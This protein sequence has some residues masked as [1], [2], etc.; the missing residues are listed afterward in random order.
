MEAGY[1]IIRLYHITDSSRYKFQA[2]FKGIFLKSWTEHGRV[3]TISKD[4]C[5]ICIIDNNFFSELN[6]TLHFFIY[7]LVW[8]DW[9][10]RNIE[11]AVLPFTT[12]K[13]CNN[14]CSRKPEMQITDTCP[15]CSHILRGSWKFYNQVVSQIVDMNFKFILKAS[16]GQSREQLKLL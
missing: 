4:P 16:F 5:H 11:K 14:C 1:F 12:R 15:S 2:Y 7:C 3:K 8:P 6:F 10:R 13:Y 9:I